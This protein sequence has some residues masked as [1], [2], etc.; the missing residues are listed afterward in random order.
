MSWDAGKLVNIEATGAVISGGTNTI[1][2][3][4]PVGKRVGGLYLHGGSWY[5]KLNLHNLGYSEIRPMNI[6][7]GL[8]ITADDGCASPYNSIKAVGGI[9]G[10]GGPAIQIVQTGSGWANFYHFTDTML[11]TSGGAPIVQ[12][13]NKSPTYAPGLW[14]FDHCDFESPGP[15]YDCGLVSCHTF[16][17][18]Y[19]EP[20]T[21]YT[22]GNL[23]AKSHVIFRDPTAGLSFLLDPRIT[24][25]GNT[26]Q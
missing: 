21:P 18:C 25:E 24:I 16:S 9:N 3:G 26:P 23:D 5:C 13:T 6:V 15:I 2:W 17:D 10:N 19:W 4:A 11:F 20:S 14:L 8:V 22:L 1:S 12:Q 7:G